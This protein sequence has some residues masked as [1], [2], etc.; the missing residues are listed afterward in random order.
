[1]ANCTFVVTLCTFLVTDS[2]YFVYPFAEGVSV[3]IYSF[4]VCCTAVFSSTGISHCTCIF[5]VGFG[6]F[7]TVIPCVL[8]CCAV[9][10]TTVY[11]LE[12]VSCILAVTVRLDC[13]CVGVSKLIDYK[14]TC[15]FLTVCCIFICISCKVKLTYCTLLV[16][17]VTSGFASCCLCG[18]CCT[19]GVTCCSNCFCIFI[20]AST[21]VSHNACFCTCRSFGFCCCVGVTCCGYLISY[22]AITASTCVGCVTFCCT[23]GSCYY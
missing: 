21:G 22:I 19:E 17:F 14:C 7:Y 4:S 6:F 1:M 3:G 23:C 12:G 10:V 2:W 5:T 11:A 8:N 13:S 15:I 16:C 20:T 18:C 9:V